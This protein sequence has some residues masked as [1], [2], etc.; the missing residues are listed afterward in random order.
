[1]KRTQNIHLDRFRKVRRVTLCLAVPLV[2]SACDGR[3]EEPFSTISQCQQQYNYTAQHCR[4]IYGQAIDSAKINGRA[5]MTREE[6]V[7][8]NRDDP[9]AQQ[10]CQYTTHGSSAHFFY[11]PRYYSYSPGGY[12]QPFYRNGS[13]SSS[14]FRSAQGK[15][16]EAKFGGRTYTKT[17]TRGGFGSTPT[18]HVSRTSSARSFGG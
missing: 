2:L 10:Q 3:R 16:Y 12:A 7:R 4:Q 11:V 5:Y 9:R 6:C 1:M 14:N 15:S 17:T 18:A 13:S 8:D